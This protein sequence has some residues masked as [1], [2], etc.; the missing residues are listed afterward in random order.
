MNN[1][2]FYCPTRVF[3]GR[4]QQ[5][6]VGEI[7]KGYGFKKVLLHYG[8]GSIKKIG[9]YDEVVKSLNDA[10]IDFVELGGAQPNPILG[11]VKKGIEIC[12]KENVE[13]VL[14]VGGGSAI[15]SGK[16]IALGAVND[17]DPWLFFAKKKEPER[18]LPVGTILT[19]SAT[20]S[21]TS[22][23]TVITNE[24]L[25]LK[26]GFNSE[27]NR[28]LFSILNPELTFTVSPYQTACGI[29]DIMMHTAERYLTLKGEAEVTDRI[30]EAVLKSTIQAGR[31]ALKNPE[32][33]EARA[34]LMWA[35][36]LSHNGLTGLGRDYFMVSHQIE[37]EIS[38]MFEE[39][40]HGAGLAVVFPAWMKYAYK[41]NIPR[42][43]QYAVRVWNCEM[44]YAN[45]ENTAI[46]GIE[47]TES[48]FKEIGMPTTLGELNITEDSIE[49]MAEKCTN[50]GERILP[51]YIEYGKKEIID[52]LRLCL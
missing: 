51:G 2:E 40:A 11:L 5:K 34:T 13:L 21:E 50:Y 39:V 30:A 15:D 7:I 47:A 36:S 27:L 18:A 24:E 38:G 42:F 46:A 19:L 26:R 4:D 25:K 17:C 48:F 6:H 35:G 49:E 1:F 28:P 8:G 37:H 9:L 22:T 31:A 44:D 23:S 3:F 32:D 10:E 20:G 41:Y 14:A 16:A 29:V 45:P 12:R 43:C 52:I 33:Y